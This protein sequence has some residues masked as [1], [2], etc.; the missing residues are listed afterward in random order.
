MPRRSGGHRRL[1]LLPPAQ[2]RAQ[3]LPPRWLER[4]GL[5]LLLLDRNRLGL[6]WFGL[7]FGL[8]FRFGLRFRFGLWFG[9]RL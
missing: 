8:W 2:A 7:W 3:P 4:L 1:L 6:L 9:L 5:G